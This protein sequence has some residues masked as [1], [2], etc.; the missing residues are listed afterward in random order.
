MS[1]R[2]QECKMPVTAPHV[3]RHERSLWHTH[4][5]RIWEML[6]GGSSE[7]DIAEAIGSTKVNVCISLRLSG[8]RKH[9]TE[10]RGRPNAA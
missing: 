5:P 10:H 3:A 8:L 1:R 4:F 7:M 2:C 9:L 6:M